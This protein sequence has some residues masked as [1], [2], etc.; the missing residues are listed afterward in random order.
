MES[1]AERMLTVPE[2]ASRL[3]FKPAYVYELRLRRL[4][5]V[6]QGKYVRV[7]ESDLVAWIESR[8]D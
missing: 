6:R 2:V 3:T 7:R 5:A 4:P 1:S 8:K